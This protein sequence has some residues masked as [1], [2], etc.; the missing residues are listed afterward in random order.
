MEET[1]Q[2]SEEPRKE[3][4]KA[5]WQPAILMFARFSGWIVA[6]VI[7]GAVLGKWLDNKYGTEPWL[8]LACVGAAF[9][10]SMIGLVKNVVE[11][12]KKIEKK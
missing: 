12:Y 8:F 6:P 5:W 7:I 2:K 10:V 11:E 9:V 3:N 1:K 4:D